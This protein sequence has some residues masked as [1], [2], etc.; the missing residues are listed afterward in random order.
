M[1][2]VIKEKGYTS[3]IVVENSDTMATIVIG[4][5]SMEILHI[6]EKEIS[7]IAEIGALAEW[8]FTVSYELASRL[9]QLTL[10]MHKPIRH[11]GHKKE[12]QKNKNIDAMDVLLGLANYV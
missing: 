11:Q 2:K 6:L 3:N 12:E 8:N 7:N 1:Y 10:K 4:K 5:T 9:A